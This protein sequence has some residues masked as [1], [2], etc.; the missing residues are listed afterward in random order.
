MQQGFE[1]YFFDAVILSS[2]NE[3][4]KKNNDLKKAKKEII[5]IKESNSYRIG[6]MM[7]FPVRCFKRGWKYFRKNGVSKTFKH[8][9]KKMKKKIN[10]K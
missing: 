1:R 6:R 2:I 8:V 4:K 3:I 5:K 10:I 7:T 9:V